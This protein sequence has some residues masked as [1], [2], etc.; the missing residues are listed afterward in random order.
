M[1]DTPERL[2]KELDL[3]DALGDMEI[4]S[5]LMQSTIPRDADGKPVNPIDARFA[6]LAL[7]SMEP[8]TRSSKEF[9]ALQAYTKDTHGATHQH[10]KVDVLHAYRVE[11][12]VVLCVLGVDSSRR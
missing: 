8:I 12:W 4:A 6:S 1:I 7:S 11:R 2:K 10:Y 9:K 5:K 3:V